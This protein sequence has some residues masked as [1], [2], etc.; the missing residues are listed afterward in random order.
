MSHP[1]LSSWTAILHE[2]DAQGEEIVDLS[3]PSESVSPPFVSCGPLAQ[4]LGRYFVGNVPY[5]VVDDGQQEALL[6]H[7]WLLFAACVALTLTTQCE[8]N[9]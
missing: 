5:E 1:K 6:W 9:G 7:G 2:F 8:S 4:L 3:F